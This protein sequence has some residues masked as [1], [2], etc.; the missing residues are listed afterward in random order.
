MLKEKVHANGVVIPHSRWK[1]MTKILH[2]IG[3]TRAEGVFKCLSPS[4]GLLIPECL[5][6]T[7]K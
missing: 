6:R 3:V 1:K 7:P 2:L 4:D 5:G